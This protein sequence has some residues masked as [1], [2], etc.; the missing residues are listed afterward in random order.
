MKFLKLIGIPFVV[1]TTTHALTLD[2]AK[3]RAEQKNPAFQ[4][5]QAEIA[6]AEGARIGAGTRANPELTIV[7][8]DTSK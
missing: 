8:A 4:V 3:A 7:S 2:Q 6:A 1:V 5:L